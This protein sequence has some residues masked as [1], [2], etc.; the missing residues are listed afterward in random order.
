MTAVSTIPMGKA[1]PT[2][3]KIELFDS[4]CGEIMAKTL[5]WK[6]TPPAQILF[7]LRSDN[8]QVLESNITQLLEW[9]KPS[10]NAYLLARDQKEQD[11]ITNGRSEI[12]DLLRHQLSFDPVLPLSTLTDFVTYIGHLEKQF[13]VKIICFAHAGDGNFHIIFLKPTPYTKERWGIVQK[14]IA[15]QMFTEV[16]RLGGTLS[17][18]HGIGTKCIPYIDYA[19]PDKQSLL[20]TLH[21]INAYK[22]CHD[23]NGIM[24]PG[25][26]EVYKKTDGTWLKQQSKL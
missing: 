23:P 14:E 19:S 10:T 2:I 18:E 25:V 15:H 13:A 20:N 4:N 9:I 1:L 22:R 16:Q 26:R 6:T 24:N 7:E 5:G 11:L 17:G 12:G 8:K 3:S 21:M